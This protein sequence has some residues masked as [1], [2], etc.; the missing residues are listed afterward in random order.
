M[1]PGAEADALCREIT[2]ALCALVDID[3]GRPIVREVIRTRDAFT[4]EHLEALPDLVVIWASEAPVQGVRS[5]A[6]GE[7]RIAS[8]EQRTGA[9]RPEGFLAA[10][11]PRIASTGRCARAH[12]VDLA[13]TFLHL[14][15]VSGAAD[16]DGRVIESLLPAGHQGSRS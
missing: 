1:S 13:P 3:S 2:D 12:I 5:A 11:G 9:H 15:G 8:P 7:I 14:A 10:A 6:L 4:G 16:A